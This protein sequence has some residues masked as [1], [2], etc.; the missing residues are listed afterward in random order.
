MPKRWKRTEA[1]P[2][3]AALPFS[4]YDLKP[5][6]ARSAAPKRRSAPKLPAPTAA[7]TPIPRAT[8]AALVG[9]A[10]PRPG[11]QRG[12]RP[13]APGAPTDAIR[14]R[15]LG[16][17]LG[18]HFAS[19]PCPS[20][21]LCEACVEGDASVSVLLTTNAVDYARAR[22]LG[23]VALH[24]AEVSA[25]TLAAELGRATPIEFEHWCELKQRT[26]E[27]WELTPRVTL[28]VYVSRH[29]QESLTLER[30]LSRCG[31]RIVNV[32]S[33][34]PAPPNFWEAHRG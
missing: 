7:E 34:C 18:R 4:G 26:R 21:V 19:L 14:V 1:L 12:A 27:A 25:L 3:T 22:E 11:P 8:P 5:A 13:S 33:V 28:G 31:A 10:A 20:T 30:V 16:A 6:Q 9:P 32:A 29:N 23:L 15:E 24:G 17:L 2:I